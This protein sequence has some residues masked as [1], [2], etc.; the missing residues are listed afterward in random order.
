MRTNGIQQVPKTEAKSLK[1][2]S[3]SHPPSLMGPLGR[4]GGPREHFLMD[5]GSMLDRFW[6][7]LGMFF[8][9]LEVYV[10]K[11]L[12]RHSLTSVLKV[13]RTLLTLPRYSGQW[14]PLPSDLSGTCSSRYIY[15]YIYPSGL[16]P[17]RRAEE[18][19]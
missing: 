19:C 4:P 5:S 17:V 14:A 18:T 2:G 6:G 13:S 1:E 9:G 11:L 12:G 7:K 10:C 3:S 8:Q 16:R 15:I